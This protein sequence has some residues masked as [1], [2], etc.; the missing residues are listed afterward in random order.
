MSGGVDPL[1][2]VTVA[3][4]DG[5]QFAAYTRARG[6]QLEVLPVEGALP[7]FAEREELRLMRPVAGDAM[8]EE[9]VTVVGPSGGGGGAVIVELAGD[10]RR[11]Q[12]RDHVRVATTRLTI[13]IEGPADADEPRRVTA[14]VLDLSAGGAR[15]E[16][17]GEP[18]GVGSRWRVTAE[19]E[20][21]DGRAL[22]LEQD[23]EVRWEVVPEPADDERDDEERPAE[24]AV[25]D[26]ADP[27]RAG[28]R[29][30]AVRP[31]TEESLTRWVFQQQ[32][33]WLRVRRQGGH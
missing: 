11:H 12:Q 25:D 13:A 16:H 31:A 27:V 9:P 5:R 20:Y 24:D 14:R 2:R 28:L 4:A 23:A 18:L 19:L 6:R 30:L 32:A 17:D 8:Y 3:R 33:R 26:D 15:V 7:S 1:I 10:R 21:D 22:P 29:F